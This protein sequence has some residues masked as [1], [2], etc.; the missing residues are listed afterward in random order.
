MGDEGDASLASYYDEEFYT[1]IPFDA[2]NCDVAVNGSLLTVNYA[3][4]MY[5]GHQSNSVFTINTDTMEEVRF[6]KIYNSHS[7]A[8]R[9]IS[10]ENGFLYAS[11]GD[12]YPRAFSVSAADLTENTCESYEVFHFWVKKNTASNGD[13]FTLNNNFAHMGGLASTGTD[14]AA[15]V[16]TSAKS[17]NSDA[18]KENEQL[19]IQVFDPSSD[20]HEKSAYI[21]DGSRSGHSGRNGDKTVTDYGVKWLTKYKKNTKF[22]NP[23]VTAAGGHYVI[24]YEKHKNSKYKGVYTM[25]LDSKGEVVSEETLYSK[26]ASLNPCTMPVYTNGFVYWNGNQYGEKG[27]KLYVYG[28]KVK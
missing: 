13:M 27:D 16:G 18:A 26:T 19:F 9:V 1:K 17:L 21:I 25:T 4:E 7:F 2:G 11:E 15:L 6:G 22:S 10:V 28:L 3:R 14:S 8:Q 24:L 23:Q 20:L 12:S 5:S